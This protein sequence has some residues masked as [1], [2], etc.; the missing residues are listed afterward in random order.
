MLGLIVYDEYCEGVLYVGGL[1][2]HDVVPAGRCGRQMYHYDPIDN[3]WTLLYWQLPYMNYGD[4]I[5]HP[6]GSFVYYEPYLI[7]LAGHKVFWIADLS[8]ISHYQ[9]KLPLSPVHNNMST[10]TAIVDDIPDTSS[11]F[12][13]K[14]NESII[15]SAN[16][17]G[18][19]ATMAWTRMNIENVIESS[20]YKNTIY[21]HGD[22][23]RGDH[24][25]CFVIP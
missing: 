24:F 15:A 18:I 13:P 19:I 11:T 16:A 6:E 3:I 23:Q 1:V 7:F 20:H 10:P 8:I 4:D 9:I 12:I 5:G 14:Y 17:R 2:D 21:Y 25:N 22:Y